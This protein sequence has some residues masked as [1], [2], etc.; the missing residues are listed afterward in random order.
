MGPWT[1]VSGGCA[2]LESHQASEGTNWLSST[3]PG[4]SLS[5]PTRA[6]QTSEITQL[7]LVPTWPGSRVKASAVFPLATTTYHLSPEART[8]ASGA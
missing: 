5:P 6:T 8:P 3:A 7:V 4:D 2:G 1:H